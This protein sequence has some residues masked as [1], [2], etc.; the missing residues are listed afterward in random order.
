MARIPPTF[1][2]GC[3]RYQSH[4]SYRSID[5]NVRGEGTPIEDG[6]S[7]VV[8]NH[9]ERFQPS[10]QARASLLGEVIAN[11]LVEGK[12]AIPRTTGL[13]AKLFRGAREDF[14]KHWQTL[15]APQSLARFWNRQLGPVATVEVHG[16]RQFGGAASELH[17]GATLVAPS[18]SGRIDWQVKRP[19]SWAPSSAGRAQC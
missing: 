12:E 16:L 1:R 11:A 4:H 5:A 18:I 8:Y 10:S 7:A 19:H 6:L 17:A 3:E 2:P 13:I 14:Y 15:N 9:A